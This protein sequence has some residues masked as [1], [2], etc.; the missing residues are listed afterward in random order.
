MER[1]RS[2]EEAKLLRSKLEMAIKDAN[3]ARREKQQ[4]EKENELLRNEL[5]VQTNKLQNKSQESVVNE[6]TLLSS[7]TSRLSPRALGGGVSVTT[8]TIT[9]A[10]AGQDHNEMVHRSPP[11]TLTDDVEYLQQKLTHYALRLEEATKTI[12]AEREE[13]VSLHKAMESL[14][15]EVNQSRQRLDE[16]RQ[17]KLDTEA[18]LLSQQ[19]Q[20]RL[21]QKCTEEERRDAELG[22]QTLDR[23]LADLRGEL[24]LLQAENAAEWGRRERLET[25]RQAL[26]RENR[27]MRVQVS[28]L[29]ERLAKLNSNNE[30]RDEEFSSQ[31]GGDTTTTATAA[32]ELE[33]RTRELIELRHAHNKLKKALH[34]KSVELS[35]GLRRAEHSEA[36]VRRLRS[37]IDELKREVATAQDELDSSTN[38]AR[39]WQRENEDLLEQV[40]SLKVQSNHLQNR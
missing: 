30:E 37:R 7:L 19:E 5:S 12:Q 11:Q 40:S 13:K 34:E 27:K 32:D 31:R 21:Q 33:E 16:L 36:E 6:E 3:V 4:M 28:D 18:R 20:H 2:R 14:Q 25:E 39:K 22:R 24:E 17:L 35:H 38:S 1:N 29:T 10:T 23:R 8:T 9:A 26:E 15:S